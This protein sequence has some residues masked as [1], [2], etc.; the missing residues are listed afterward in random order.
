ME[1][2]TAIARVIFGDVN[3]GGKLPFTV[4]E[5]ESMYPDFDRS[6]K[7]ATYDRYHGYIKLDHDRNKAAFPFRIRPLIYRV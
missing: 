4:A 6:A 5:K 3:P 1:G 7:T 2:G